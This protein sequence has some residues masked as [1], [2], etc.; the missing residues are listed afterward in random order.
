[1]EEMEEYE[2]NLD[3]IVSG[4][5]LKRNYRQRNQKYIFRRGIR[6]DIQPYLAEGWER[7]GP[8]TE[9]QEQLGS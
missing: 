4:E 1:M 7:V 2:I 9:R 8:G 6:G 5:A 3:D